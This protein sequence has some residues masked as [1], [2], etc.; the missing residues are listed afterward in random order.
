VRLDWSEHLPIW[1]ELSVE[2]SLNGEVQL[3]INGLRGVPLR[4]FR[5]VPLDEP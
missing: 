3:K 2:T 1:N 4:F 5:A